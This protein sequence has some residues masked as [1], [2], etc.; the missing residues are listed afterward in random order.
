MMMHRA[1]LL[2]YAYKVLQNP[3]HGIVKDAKQMLSQLIVIR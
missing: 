1:V 2:I 3:Y